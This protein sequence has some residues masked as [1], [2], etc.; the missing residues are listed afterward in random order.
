MSASYPGASRP[1]R[2]PAPATARGYRGSHA[3]GL[4]Q[5]GKAPADYVRH[6]RAHR[7]RAARYCPVRQRDAS[8]SRRASCPPSRKAPSPRPARGTASVMRATRSPPKLR[9]QNP[10]R[11]RVQMDAVSNHF[12]GHVRGIQCRAGDTGVAVVKTAACR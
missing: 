10:H 11:S 6:D 8:A 1:L 12:N 7:R 2:A 4:L 9:Q 5:S 3:H